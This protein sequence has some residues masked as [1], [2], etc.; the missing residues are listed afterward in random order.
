M[1]HIALSAM[2]TAT[3]YEQLTRTQTTDTFWICFAPMLTLT[4]SLFKSGDNNNNNVHQVARCKMA[5]RRKVKR[6][7]T[8][9]Q[10]TR[11]MR[12]VPNS[13]PSVPI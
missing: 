13:R 1:Y 8:S 11:S 12:I 4:G 9:K 3:N 2:S 5:M 7:R 6:C 10:Q